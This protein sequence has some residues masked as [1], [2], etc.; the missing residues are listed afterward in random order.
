MSNYLGED[1]QRSLRASGII[2]ENEVVEK[3]GDLYVAVN[4]INGERRTINIDASVLNENS[5]RVLR[6]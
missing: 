3:Q 6:G 5:K 4:V 1:L 2:K